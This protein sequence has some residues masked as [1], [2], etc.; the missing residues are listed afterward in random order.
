MWRF[1]EI[2]DVPAEHSLRLVT[3]VLDVRAGKTPRRWEHEQYD[4]S[5]RLVAVYESWPREGA[6]PAFVKYSP[7]GWVLSISGR[8]PRHPPQ[9][10]RFQRVGA[11]SP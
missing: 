4:A 5:G 1:E 10:A 2:F 7:N 11:A 6:S 3:G 8:S 9:R